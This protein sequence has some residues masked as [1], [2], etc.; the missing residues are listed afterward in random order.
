[1][2]HKS[3]FHVHQLHKPPHYYRFINFNQVTPMAGASAGAGASSG[4]GGYSG[5]AGGYASA[6]GYAGGSGGTGG[7][8]RGGYNGSGAG[9]YASQGGLYSGGCSY[10]GL[11]PSR[12]FA[13]G[14]SRLSGDAYR[15]GSYQ[16]PFGY[17]SGRATGYQSTHPSPFGNAAS[18][19]VGQSSSSSRSISQFLGSQTP[20]T[21]PYHS[22][23]IPSRP[24][25]YDSCKPP[26]YNTQD[27]GES[28]M[29]MMGDRLAQK[30]DLN[31][32][33]HSCRKCGG[34]SLYGAECARCQIKMSAMP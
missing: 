32:R 27:F 13:S 9:S 34:F 30:Q 26:L 17:S 12:G 8:A 16:T 1:M 6:G 31:N 29:A 7:Y 24:K 23:A 3:H 28:V 2:P 14:A 11:S 20:S 25:S 19:P 22:R 4:V 21:L 33:V 15:F 18:T 5:L 10:P